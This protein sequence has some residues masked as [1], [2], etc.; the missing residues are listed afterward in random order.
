M[1]DPSDGLGLANANVL[2]HCLAIF[3][4]SSFLPLQGTLWIT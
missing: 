3:H 2:G 1:A 4:L